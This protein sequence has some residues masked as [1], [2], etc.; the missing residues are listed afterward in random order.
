METTDRNIV[1]PQIRVVASAKGELILSA[2]DHDCVNDSG[3]ILLE[4]HRFEND[5]RS[6]LIFR[7][8]HVYKIPSLVVV[9]EA[10][11]VVHL[12]E[13]AFK[14]FPRKCVGGLGGLRRHLCM[15]PCFNA[16]VVDVLHRTNTVTSSD[17]GILLSEFLNP[18]E[19][20]HLILIFLGNNCN[21][22]SF[23]KV[24]QISISR[25]IE[26][27]SCSSVLADLELYSSY[28]DDVV[29]SNPVAIGFQTPDN[30][31][32]LLIWVSVVAHRLHCKVVY[33]LETTSYL[34]PGLC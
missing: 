29:E 21:L 10:V 17:L 14:V 25:N 20:T 23:I 15:E 34:H 5:V 12:A 1:D 13:L 27:F 3:R 22:S 24:D 8:R 32:Q 6:G 7:T 2:V 9:T 11:G 16:I 31:P 18:A 19:P 26:I 30:K 28:F 33:K 4:I